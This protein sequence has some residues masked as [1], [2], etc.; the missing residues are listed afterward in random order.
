MSASS[1]YEMKMPVIE[2]KVGVKGSDVYDST[3]SALLDLSVMLVRGLSEDK[4]TAGVDA[5]LKQPNSLEDFCVLIFQTCNIR[6]GKGERTLAYDLIKS[7]AKKDYALSL[8]LL[9]LFP[10]QPHFVRNFCFRP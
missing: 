10:S 2:Q 1:N 3:G 6:G 8:D 5:V 4:I 9:P 7:L